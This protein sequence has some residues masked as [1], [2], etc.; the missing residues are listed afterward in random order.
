MYLIVIGYFVSVPLKHSSYSI[1]GGY[2]CYVRFCFFFLPLQ[3]RPLYTFANV[4][5]GW[6]G[7]VCPYLHPP[8]AVPDCWQSTCSWAGMTAPA[9][10]YLPNTSPAWFRTL[11]PSDG[12]KLHLVVLTCIFQITDE[13]KPRVYEPF[14]FP[15]LWRNCSSLLPLFLLVGLSYSFVGFFLYLGH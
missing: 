1:L 10:L 13:V 7:V 11:H 2:L 6:P 8:W 5:L 14:A 12:F 9:A 3:T 15:L 4:S